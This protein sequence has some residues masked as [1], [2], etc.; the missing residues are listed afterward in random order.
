MTTTTTPTGRGI[1]TIG[2]TTGAPAPRIA[3]GTALTGPLGDRITEVLGFETIAGKYSKVERRIDDA[4]AERL[5]RT[6][7]D[8]LADALETGRRKERVSETLLDDLADAAD[9]ERTRY[10]NAATDALNTI[11][12]QHA[13]ERTERVRDLEAELVGLVEAE[14]VDILRE[15]EKAFGAIDG[16]SAEAAIRLGLTDEWQAAKALAARWTDA[17]RNRAWVVQALEAGFGNHEIPGADPLRLARSPL[18][19]VSLGR[20]VWEKQFEGGLDIDNADTAEDVLN[21]WVSLPAAARPGPV[22]LLVEGI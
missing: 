14:L 6:R 2:T 4:L 17:Q 8:L 3:F 5:R 19:G 22:V 9:G 20:E 1:S 13:T 11:R 12:R 21:A 10:S 16:V 7:A 15:A 18:Y